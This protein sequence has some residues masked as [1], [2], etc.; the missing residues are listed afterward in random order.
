MDASLSRKGL[1]A[2]GPRLVEPSV[3]RRKKNYRYYHCRRC[4]GVS[5][6][7][8][9]L[10]SQFIGLLE[11]LR[12]RAEFMGLFRAIVLD[13]WR[14]RREDA[15][16]LRRDLEGRLADLQQREMVL[17]EAFL[18]ERRIDS[19]AYERQRDKV[20]ENIA[21]IRIEL[22][23][24]RIEE[25]DVEG[26]LG[27]AQHVLGNAAALW[28]DATPEQK[29]RLQLALFLQGLRFKEG[30]FGTAIT[31]LAF[32]QLAGESTTDLQLASPTGFEPV[33]WP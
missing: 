12:P 6:R 29:Q 22:E 2:L 8:E 23:D 18:Y 32:M 28:S 27:Y 16:R 10:E 1:S 17:D 14:A 20:R 11:S 24:A 13:V 9:K 15:G 4:K 30:T 25:I 3:P 7:A 31:C 19:A 5:I 21:L 33:F 26:I